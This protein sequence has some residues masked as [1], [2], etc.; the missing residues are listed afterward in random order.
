MLYISVLFEF[1]QHITFVIRKKD[2][3]INTFNE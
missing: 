3:K 2:I 1:S